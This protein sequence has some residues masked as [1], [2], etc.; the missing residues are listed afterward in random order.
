[1]KF[2]LGKKYKVAHIDAEPSKVFGVS[3]GDVVE[4]HFIDDRG[5]I[6]TRDVTW[7]GEDINNPY[8]DHGAW[9]FASPTDTEIILEELL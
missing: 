9:C 4:C 2:L 8:Y 5:Y 1:M 7:L 6:W 3:V